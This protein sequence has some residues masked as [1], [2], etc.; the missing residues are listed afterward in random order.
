VPRDERSRPAGGR[1][2]P[3]IG[4]GEPTIAVDDTAPARQLPTAAAV[5]YPPAGRRSRWLA[6]VADCPLCRGAHTHYGAALG[7]LAGGVR[8]ASCGHGS[9]L[10]QAGSTVLGVAA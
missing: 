3:K 7:E 1:A 10:L 6:V 4:G 8:A 5:V 9:Y 2:A